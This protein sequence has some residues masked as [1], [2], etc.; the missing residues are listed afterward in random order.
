MSVKAMFYVSEIKKTPSDF[1][2]VT[3]L[4]VTRSKPKPTSEELAE[5]SGYIGMNTDWSKYTPSGKLEMN[6]STVTKAAQ[7]FEDRLGKD[8][9]INFEDPTE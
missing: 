8:V 5:N 7:W 6:V 9:A 4:P 2:A 3:L 1:V